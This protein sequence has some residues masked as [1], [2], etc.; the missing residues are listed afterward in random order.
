M[1]TANIISSPHSEPNSRLTLS[2][3]LGFLISG[4]LAL[5][6]ILA[7]AAGMMLFGFTPKSFA[8]FSLP[9]RPGNAPQWVIGLSILLI[10][11]LL[12]AAVFLPVWAATRRRPAWEPLHAITASL[13]LASLYL[14]GWNLAG[15]PFEEQS[16][17]PSLIRLLL[18]AVFLGWIF[19]P[20]HRQAPARF[21]KST[22]STLLLAI[23][24]AALL[25]LPWGILGAL[26][27]IQDTLA[28]L[29]TAL[30]YGVGE[31]ILLRGVVAALVARAT[32]RPRIGF[33]AGIL[34][35]LAM[36]PGYML[37]LGDWV[38]VFRLFNT[39]AV[40]LLASEL[41][42]RGSLGAAILVH[43]AF[44]FGFPAWVDGRM[45]FSL[46]H[47]AALESLGLVFLLG[48]F[49]IA[50]RMISHWVPKAQPA[51]FR[52]SAAG[53]FAVIALAGSS[54]AYAAWG[55]P[56]FTNEGFLI[57]FREQ[58]DLSSAQSIPGRTGRI[59]YIYQALTAT[60]A[61]VQ[62]PVRAEL[63]RLGLEYRPH[64]LINMIEVRGGTG[65][66]A[67]FAARADVQEVVPNP[68][69]RMANYN[70]S[71]DLLALPIPGQ[72]V[73]WNITAVGA[74]SVWERGVDGSGIVVAVA[75]TGVDW[76][77]PA[78]QSKYRGVADGAGSHDYNWYDPWDET[79]APWDDVG[80]GTYTLGTVVGEDGTENRIGM[81]PGA[82]WI[83]CRNMR[84]GL[85]NPGMYIACME[86][87][88][89]PFPIGGDPFREGRPE[90]A[91]HVVNNSWGCPEREGCGAQTLAPALRI[92]HLAGIMM[93]AAAGN[94]GPACATAGDPPANSAVVF[95][96][97]ASDES[98]TLAFFSSRGPAADVVKPDIT[99][100]GWMVRSAIPG[101]KYTISAGTS[102]AAP[103]VTGAVALLW[104]AFPELVGDIDRTQDLLRRSANPVTIAQVCG[105]LEEQGTPC[106]CGGDSGTAVPNNSYG[107][108][109]LN[110]DAAY[111][112]MVFPDTM[113]IP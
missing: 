70:E 23:G 7:L 72:G 50:V 76:V 78:L 67:A 25:L 87:F 107:S 74:P 105:V 63:E 113:A 55:H 41:A 3:L 2:L 94:D 34:I 61:R 17:F 37:P 21:A 71:M 97:G 84:S 83:A 47:P 99:A 51:A 35:G 81:A 13:L 44:E 85:G 82:K 40:A 1:T 4:V 102:I 5:A 24:A 54:A 96:V 89:A 91:P 59:A 80:H 66:M 79:P 88:L 103:H 52:L 30:A 60:A 101:G 110:V 108:G 45:E 22:T 28:A 14:F 98:D 42:A 46:P 86:F 38:T 6:P 95:T 75:D 69:V 106:L 77:H 73:E 26:G 109:I 20:L 92:L 31:E 18:A 48:L 10:A 33:L 12:Q 16:V 29:V 8:F 32:G 57:V 64:Y 15:L 68:N 62:A 104:S 112:E 9:P 11:V 90:L 65:R 93:I 111:E 56:G 36:Q 39:V 43:S 49:F 53:A 27:S 58:A 100:P 19:H